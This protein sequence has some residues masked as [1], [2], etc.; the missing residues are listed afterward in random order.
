MYR[1]TQ[2]RMNRNPLATGPV[3]LGRRDL[4]RFREDPEN[5]GALSDGPA[6]WTLRDPDDSIELPRSQTIVR[7]LQAPTFGDLSTLLEGIHSSVHVWVGGA[8]TLISV[9]AYDPLFWAH[10]AMIDR[11]WYLWQIT[12]HG[13][14][15][16]EILDRALRPFPMTVRDTLDI[17]RLGYGYALRVVG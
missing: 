5:A 6:P 14:V 4:G 16:T 12:T 13:T 15:P 17:R 10:H 11:L 2:A 9:A 3:A 8:M 7:A 1:R